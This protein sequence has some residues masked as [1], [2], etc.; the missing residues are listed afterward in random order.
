LPLTLLS[1]SRN[2]S[3]PSRNQGRTLLQVAAPLPLR[4]TLTYLSPGD[5]QQVAIGARV[6]VLVGNRRLIGVVVEQRKEKQQDEAAHY[7]LKPVQRVI[8]QQPL[9]SEHLMQLLLWAAQYYQFPLGLVLQQALPGLMRKGGSTQTRSENA[10]RLRVAVDSI[11]WQSFSR[12]PKQQQLLRL[13]SDREGPTLTRDLP[14]GGDAWRASI[15]ALTKKAMIEKCQVEIDSLG[16]SECATDLPGAES[17]RLNAEQQQV[18]DVVVKQRQFEVTL[19]HGITGS[20]KTE[21]YMQI[22]RQVCDSGRQCMVIVPE[23][24]LTPQLLQRFRSRFSIPVLTLHSALSDGERGV[25]WLQSAEPQPCIVIGTRSAAFAP[26]PKLGV[27]IIDEE[28]DQSLKQQDGFRFSA[29]DVLI[30]RAQMLDVPIVLGSATPSLESLQHAWLGQYHYLELK[31]RATGASAPR[32]EILDVRGQKLQ[33]GLSNRLISDMQDTLAAG[34]QVLLFLNRRGFAPVLL[35]HDCGWSAHCQRCDSHM[36]LFQ[37]NQRLRCHHCDSQSRVPE[38]C[39]QCQGENL[40]AVGEGTERVEEK[41]NQLFPDHEVVRIDRDS[42]R[43]KGSFHAM[44]ER[45]HSGQAHILLGTQ[46]LAKGHDFPNVTLVGVLNTDQGLFS[47]DFRALEHMGQLLLQVA[48]R[49]GRG[50]APG[51][52]LV[53]THQP[54]HPILHSLL[55]QGYAQFARDLL[56]QREEAQLPPYGYLSLLRAEAS[57]EQLAMDFLRMAKAQLLPHLP[58][59]CHLWGPALAPMSKRAGRFRAQLMLHQIERK[60]RTQL[61]QYWIEQLQQL[62]LARKVRWSIDVDPSN[63]Y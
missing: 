26:L 49:A 39:P 53:Q 25:H 31:Q 48:G 3:S 43:R 18:V 61:L 56:A 44:L 45:I 4:H 57:Q 9:L 58:D 7:T 51:S 23:I 5:S 11:D 24:G 36:S 17:P 60:G 19:V 2:P 21:V 27:I 32:C 62:P 46:M 34:K 1:P 54:Q 13:L 12:A 30:K 38:R 14:G 55:Q 63:L 52:V 37:G 20:G 29:R 47:V 6:E 10:W 59:N 40:I 35:C 33:D 22:C 8:D 15:S 42:T 16:V 41:L 28:H 50:D